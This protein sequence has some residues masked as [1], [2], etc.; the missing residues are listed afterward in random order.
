MA[1]NSCFTNPLDRFY[2]LLG[3]GSSDT[4]PEFQDVEMIPNYDMSVADCYREFAKQHLSI[5]DDMYR[6]FTAVQHDRHVR[7][8]W[9]SWTPD[10]RVCKTR[11]GINQAIYELDLSWFDN[12]QQ[13]GPS[14]Q[15]EQECVTLRGFRIATLRS[16]IA[17]KPPVLGHETILGH[18]VISGH[19]VWALEKVYLKSLLVAMADLTSPS[20]IG[21]AAC[22]GHSCVERL[23]RQ[24]FGQLEEPMTIDG[25]FLPHHFSAT[26]F[27][28]DWTAEECE[29]KVRERIADTEIHEEM[30]KA[31]RE[32]WSQVSATNFE[33][34]ARQALTGRAFF[35]TMG[36]WVIVGP[37]MAGGG[38]EVVVVHG[39]PSPFLL[40]PAADGMWYMLGECYVPSETVA[41]IAKEK[42]DKEEKF[43]VFTIR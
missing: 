32:K 13:I 8:D 28:N 11:I 35:Q 4:G 2:G 18:E 22:V 7:P 25:D 9:P 29:A 10:W 1:R 30:D 38:D 37:D 27:L 16:L 39:C 17:D 26:A 23:H 36:K 12:I 20:F 19:E 5:H 42:L 14:M 3:M 40:R 15:G 31:S 24:P 21:L 34:K 43:E 33:I 41:D 6:L